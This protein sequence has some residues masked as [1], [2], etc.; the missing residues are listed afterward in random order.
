[1]P[2]R[3]KALED[4]LILAKV[5]RAHGVERHRRPACPAMAALVPGIYD[6]ETDA[7]PRRP[8]ILG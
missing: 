7:L 6:H 2:A 8:L 3:R 5:D 4:P 1:M